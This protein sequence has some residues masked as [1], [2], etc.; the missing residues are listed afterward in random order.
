MAAYADCSD[1]ESSCSV[2]ILT[3]S[4]TLKQ[5]RNKTRAAYASSPVIE[6]QKG[7]HG[8]GFDIR[9]CNYCIKTFSFKTVTSAFMCHIKESHNKLKN[10][11]FTYQTR[12]SNW[13]KL[14]WLPLLSK[15]VD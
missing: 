7:D 15:E 2:E 13:D 1:S 8:K 9:K 4:P 14:E 3:E 11:E 10:P 12:L 5:S 6:R